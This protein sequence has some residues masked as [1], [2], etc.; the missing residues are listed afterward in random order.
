M[1]RGI[2]G[3][4][5]LLGL[6]LPRGGVPIA[7]FQAC[8]RLRHQVGAIICLPTP[9]HFKAAGQWHRHFAQFDD[10]Q[11]CSLLGGAATTAPAST[12]PP[13]SALRPPADSLPPGHTSDPQTATHLP[14]L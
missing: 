6:G 4:P 3:W 10:G 14:D 5:Y 13:P 1:Q 12:D 8:R 9:A 11:V 7:T 2:G